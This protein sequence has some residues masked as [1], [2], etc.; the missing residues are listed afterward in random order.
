[1]QVLMVGVQQL[2][3]CEITS[4]GLTEARRVSLDLAR[5]IEVAVAWNLQST[6]EL[7]N[8]AGRRVGPEVSGELG[9][10]QAG[11]GAL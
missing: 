3:L 4:K 5:H 1:M 6:C 8:C 9:W 2:F 11:A 7:D 10:G